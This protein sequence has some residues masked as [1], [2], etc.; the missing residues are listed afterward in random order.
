M[1]NFCV[2][3][4]IRFR[5]TLKVL[6]FNIHSGINWSGHYDLEQI[7]AFIGGIK[8][9]LAGIQEVS[10]FWSWRTNFQDMVTF[11]GDRL[12]MLPAFSASLCRDG[13]ASFGNLILTKY[14]I[15]NTWSEILPDNREPRSYL[16]AQVLANGVRVNFLT[17]H[18][19]LSDKERLNQVNKIV[20][21]GTQLSGPL[22]ITGDFNEKPNGGG[23]A[24]IRENWIKHNLSPPQGTLRLSDHE[25]GPEIDMIF[26]SSDWGLKSMR[27]YENEL[28]DHLPVVAELELNLPWTQVAG[29]PVS[30]L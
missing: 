8:P 7:A 29:E 26:T 16:A 6:T 19:G 5:I 4:S 24:I 27:V 22:I 18:L 2:L 10:R 21:F 20:K 30:K 25:V 28:S 23:I 15:I 14:P 13:K 12:G 1:I 11:L 3:D 9:D 17:A